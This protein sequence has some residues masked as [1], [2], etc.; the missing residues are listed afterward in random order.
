MLAQW[1]SLGAEFGFTT[2][3]IFARLRAVAAAFF[4]QPQRIFLA[5]LTLQIDQPLLVVM[6]IACKHFNLAIVHQIQIINGS[7]QQV[8]V[9]RDQDQRG[10]E[11]DQ[12][13][14]QRLAHI[15]I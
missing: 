11:I 4:L 2:F 9:M 8:T 14:G 6:Q 7:T 15:K 10:C 13:F 3:L 1:L 12:C 5:L